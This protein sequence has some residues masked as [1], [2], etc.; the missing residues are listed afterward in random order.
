MNLLIIN[1]C[2]GTVPGRRYI[3]TMEHSIIF[4]L[5][6]RE[7]LIYFPG[8]LIT[9]QGPGTAFDFALEI[10]QALVGTEKTDSVRKA[11]LL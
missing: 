7:H 4:V 2:A 8:N 1:G 10:S 11:L 3:F 5:T 9:S 6:K